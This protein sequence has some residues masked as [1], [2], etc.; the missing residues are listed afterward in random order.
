MNFTTIRCTF[1]GFA[2]ATLLPASQL[3]LDFMH[4]APP[5]SVANITPLGAAAVNFASGQMNIT[6]TKSGDGARVALNDFQAMC[7]VL[8]NV[9]FQNFA[10]G[11]GLKFFVYDDLITGEGIGLELF[12][13]NSITV[14]VMQNNPDGTNK[15]LQKIDVPNANLGDIGRLRLDWIKA[16]TPGGP[17]QVQAEVIGKRGL[18]FVSQR[19]DTDLVHKRLPNGLTV[20]DMT[21]LSLQADPTFSVGDM[22]FDD[23]HVPEP[24]SISLFTLPAVLL[25]MSKLLFRRS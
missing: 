1:I 9:S 8:D 16:G 21:G 7:V 10:F 22:V 3:T 17:E 24:S 19:V 2:V 12:Q 14:K 15:I 4:G 18:S 6:E 23:E 5:P 11:D 20:V 13:A 25:V